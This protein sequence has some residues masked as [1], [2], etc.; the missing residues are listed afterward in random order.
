MVQLTLSSISKHLTEE[1]IDKAF[2][3]RTNSN[4]SVQSI[5]IS[6]AAPVGEG[7]ISAV[8]RIQVNGKIHTA[9]FI[10][11]GLVR[12]PLLKKS[13]TC[14]TYSKRE[15]FFFSTILPILCKTQKNS[16]SKENLQDIIPVCYG[17]HS[18]G[19]EDYILLADLAEAGFVSI[20][21]QPTIVEMNLT[22]KALAHFHAASFALRIKN[23]DVFE[24]IANELS[25]LYYND[26]KRNWYAKYFQN[27]I[28]INKTV[29]AEFESP[30]SIYYQKYFS[31]VNGDAY[32]E[33]MRVSSSRGEH[34][35]FNHG[36][37][38]CSNF[39][40]SKESAV[41]IDFQLM[42]CASPVTDLAYFITMCSNVCRTR[43]EFLD[44]VIHYYS[45]LTYYLE[46]M[47]IDA[48]KVFSFDMLME[49]LK[50]Y[51]RFGILAA[52]TS[53]PLVASERCDTLDSFSSLYSD[54]DCIPLEV[55]WKLTP[56][57]NEEHK[58][59]IVNA[60]RVTVDV[61]LI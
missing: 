46:D 42:R 6:R 12:D 31:M 38:W 27:A 57:E 14:D 53:I 51:G 7:L 3:L 30:D 37:A 56:V 21:E 34:A 2:K 15:V 43:E 52:I 47:D 40:C 61:G 58:K 59:R 29:L 23:P 16:G 44:A 18:D 20:S 60:I 28:E 45:S 13:I 54:L 36:D 10:V 35:V 19:N 24:E 8:Y 17:Q 26:E 39:L 55:L 33:L 25:E 49:E 22:L 11:K 5:T 50:K 1:V 41:A 4:D 48:S 9:K 32:G